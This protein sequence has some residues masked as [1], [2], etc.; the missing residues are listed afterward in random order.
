METLLRIGAAG[1]QI[2]FG[3]A[4]TR[5]ER[6]AVRAQ[7]FRVY[8]RHGYYHSGLELDRDDYDSRGVYLAAMLKRARPATA[9]IGS[10]RLIVG[11]ADT[12]FIFPSQRAFQFELPEAIR[13]I[14]S[15]QCTEVTRLVSERPEGIVAGGLLVPLGLIQ[16]VSV[17]SRQ[18]AIRCGLAV[19]KQR[20]LR[21]LHAAGVPLSE[22][23]PARLIYP[24]DGPTGPYYHRHADPV[25]PVWWSAAQLAPLAARAIARYQRGPRPE[26]ALC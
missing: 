2:D 12:P 17:Y 26:R 10:A 9:L 11:A 23:S 18:H 1:R 8:Q 15:Y 13:E 21:A 22:I 3:V 19:V 4:T 20:L 6:A 16:A 14:A 7:R 25:I 5:G 24:E